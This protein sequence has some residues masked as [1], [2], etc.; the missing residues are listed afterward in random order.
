[1]NAVS[2]FPKQI[3][4]RDG[5]IVDFDIARIN[6]AIFKAMEASGQPN[7][8][9]AKEL[10]EQIVRKLCK[11][12]KKTPKFI[13]AIEEIQDLIEEILIE[14][15]Y[16]KVAKN[17][18][19]YRQKR[20]EI[21]AEKQKI[22]NKE[23]IDDVDKRFDVNALRVLASRY[24]RRDEKGK[25]IESP[26]QLFERVAVHAALPA[27]LYDSTVTVSKPK[28]SGA[29]IKKEEK[30][31]EDEAAGL[32]EKLFIGKYKLNRFHIKG[33]HYL[34]VRFKK[35][36]QT[37][38]TWQKLLEMLG[39][40]EFSKYE[41]NIN[42]FY[43]LMISR[44]FM[45]NTPAVANFGSYLGMGSACFALDIDDSIESI[46]GTLKNASIVFKSGG[47]L[48]YNF[49]KLRPEGD[50]IKTTGGTSSGPISFMR[51]FDTMT[52]VVK[53]GGIRRGANM[54]ILNSNHPDIEKFIIAKKGNKALK[55][56]N[57]SVLIMS[58]FWEYY[59]KNLPYP[60]INPRTG[61]P[62][63]YAG[64]RFLFEQI[65]YSAWESAEPGVLFHDRI[66]EYNP[67]LK[68]LGPIATTNPCGELL[69]YPDESCNLGSINVWSFIKTDSRERKSVDWKALAKAVRTGVNFLDNALDIN[70]FPLK[71][72]EDM[73]LN[74][75]KIGLGLMGLGDLLFDLKI[76]FNSEKGMQFMEKLMEFINYHSKLES[77]ELAKERGAFPYFGKSFYAE[78]RLPFRGFDDKKSWHFDWQR[79]AKEIQK[80]GIRNSYTTVIAPTGSIS[81]IAGCSSGIEPVYSL[82][83]SKN[84][85]VGSFYFIN[86][87]F[88]R[89]MLRQGLF[90]D[91]LIKDIANSHGSTQG[92]N[93]IPKQVKKIFV[94]SHD[95]KPE[96]HV[97]TLAVFQKWVDSSVSKTNNFPAKA[98][99]DDMKKSYLLAYEL[100]CK[101]VTVYRD[102]SIVDQVLVSSEN[103][104]PAGGEPKKEDGKLISI[105]D[106]KAGGMA[107]Y[108]DPSLKIRNDGNN[109]GAGNGSAEAE[110][111]NGKLVKCPN[112]KADLVNQEGCIFC[113]VCGWGLCV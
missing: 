109:N 29:E 107:V 32:E 70:A 104:S 38:I 36:K 89:E 92:V 15:G 69:L 2:N 79:L 5:R 111:P 96:D 39:N 4:K 90:D 100:G 46:M 10:S 82:A 101:G 83:F 45:P 23:E 12:H 74:T 53:Q 85:A 94:T 63:R 84:V 27:I 86:P 22:L 47:G 17:Y 57:I 66:N 103:R 3:K 110:F 97:K 40:N 8:K 34:F 58:D 98:T 11:K 50:F 61:K 37:K 106:E 31:G 77:I 99:M 67:F 72:I 43:D 73:S 21:R 112:C 75:R 81:M 26:R 7:R 44:R 102:T 105:K 30:I 93:Y 78:G 25:V 60:L 49:S 33:L 1:M 76:P 80:G 48:G 6:A 18:I 88:E 20:T 56:F 87:I 113:Q 13:P 64:A 9:A 19:L 55:N 35:N 91:I 65:V 71:P 42:E 51:L 41:K 108:H 28:I 62:S 54:G 95:I 52:E 59:K 24:L 68:T 16:A 14:N